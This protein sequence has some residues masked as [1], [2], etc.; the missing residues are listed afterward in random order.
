MSYTPTVWKK[1]D[2]ITSEKL[3]KLENGVAGSGGG[4]LVVHAN[5]DTGVFDKTWQEI[6]DALAAGEIVVL[7]SGSI[8]GDEAYCTVFSAAV[9]LDAAYGIWTAWQTIGT[10]APF[11]AADS[12]DGYPVISDV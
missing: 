9:A 3:N 6:H 11:A 2:K 12:A 10:D 1:G 8:G 4:V 7:P 5:D